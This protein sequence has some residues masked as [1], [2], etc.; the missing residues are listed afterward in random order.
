MN[1]NALVTYVS[2]I[3][4]DQETANEFLHWDEALVREAVLEALAA[5][6]QRAPHAFIKPDTYTLSAGSSQDLPADK[7]EM[8]SVDAQVCGSGNFVTLHTA[9]DGSAGDNIKSGGCTSCAGRDP[10]GCNAVDPCG[11]WKLARWS[12][13][14]VRPFSF[15]VSPPVPNDG[16]VRVL[17]ISYLGPVEDGGETALTDK[18]KPAVVTYA[19]HRL[20]TVDTESQHHQAK[21]KDHLEAFA[22]LMGAP[23]TGG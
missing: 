5:V 14:A 23:N 13:D 9:F 17:N 7:R 12:W 18:W 2:S 10:F 22:L 4:R 11:S 19:L 21:A 1:V 6:A 3:L 8:F 15:S 16:I 20:Y